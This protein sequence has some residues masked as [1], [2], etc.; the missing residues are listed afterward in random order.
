MPIIDLIGKHLF[1]RH[2]RWERRHRVK[3]FFTGVLIAFIVIAFLGV[4]MVVLIGS[5]NIKLEDVL[6]HVYH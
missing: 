4:V 6:Q 5:V 2:K 1:P 3:L